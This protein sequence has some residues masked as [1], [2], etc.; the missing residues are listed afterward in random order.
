MVPPSC[1]CGSINPM[2]TVVI[3]CYMYHKPWNS[4]TFLRQLNDIQRGPHPVSKPRA[5]CHLKCACHPLV[6]V[7]NPPLGRDRG[8]G[9][10]LRSLSFLVSFPKSDL[11][12]QNSS[13]LGPETW[14]KT[15]GGFLSKESP[16]VTIWF[17]YV[18]ILKLIVMTW[19]MWGYPHDLEK[20]QHLWIISRASWTLSNQFYSFSDLS[21]ASR[22]GRSTRLVAPDT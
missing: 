4:A 5:F 3:W 20:T 17:Q 15:N 7:Q 19:I 12:W 18:S 9:D 10:W 22:K 8:D 11:L 16:V 1:V 13:K 6:I 14:N 21:R 2:K